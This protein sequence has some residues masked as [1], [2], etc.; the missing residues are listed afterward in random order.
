MSIHSLPEAAEIDPI[1]VVD[2]WFNALGPLF[3]GR[4]P[5]DDAMITQPLVAGWRIC[6]GAHELAVLVDRDF[7]FTKVQVR[8]LHSDEDCPRPHIERNGKLCLRS[9]EV[10]SDPTRAVEGALVEALG[11]LEEN[12]IGLHNEDFQ[13]DFTRYWNNFHTSDTMMANA[14]VHN[15]GGSR[16]GSYLTNSDDIFIFECKSDAIRYWN[17]LSGNRPRHLRQAALIR[18]NPLPAPDRYPK[19][20]E[21][22]WNLTEC[23]SPNG[24]AI[25]AELL[26]GEPKSTVVVLMGGAASGR[27]HVVAL[28]LMR[29]K[30]PKGRTC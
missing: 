7:P 8:L 17:N 22:L 25:L 19:S 20:G 16:F 10:P 15:G 13:E 5:A 24:S 9:A 26:R 30:D 12:D 6:V 23:R 11:L 27:E 14:K 2:A 18:I 1:T 28:Q 29:S 4:L 3:V 21:E